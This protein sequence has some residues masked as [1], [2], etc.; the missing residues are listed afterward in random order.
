MKEVYH[1]VKDRYS[2]TAFKQ[3]TTRGLIAYLDTYTGVLRPIGIFGEH[4]G[5][6]VV[7]FHSGGVFDIPFELFSKMP[8]FKDPQSHEL[9]FTDEDGRWTTDDSFNA[10]VVGT[11]VRIN[12]DGTIRINLEV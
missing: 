11:A 7:V 10:I 4:I 12:E 5:D 2:L 3:N 1:V 6:S 8:Q 9:L